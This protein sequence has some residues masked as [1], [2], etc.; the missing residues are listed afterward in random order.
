MKVIK[1]NR[2]VEKQVGC[3]KCQCVMAYTAKDIKTEIENRG[4]GTGR[5]GNYYHQ[6]YIRCAECTHRINL[7]SFL[8]G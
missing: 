5:S 6:D 4:L 8:K 7:T 3:P 1:S 2:E